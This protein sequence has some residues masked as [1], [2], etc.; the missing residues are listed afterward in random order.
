MNQ[1]F[2]HLDADE[3]IFFARE[4]E[5]IKSKSYDIQFAELKARSLIPVSSEAGPGA[6]SITY[7]QYD[8]VGVA[9]II[10]SYADDLPRADIKAKEF[11]SIVKSLGSSYGYNL[12]EIR[13]AKMAGKSLSER[14]LKAARRAM[15]QKENSAAWFG[16]ADANCQGL[17]DNA[18]INSVTIPNDG[19]GPST[20]FEDKT[21]DKILRDLNSMATAI[22]DVTL[23]VESPDTLLMPLKQYNQIFT[24]QLSTG[25]D[26]TIGKFFLE[27]SPHIKEIVWLNELKDEGG[28]GVDS[29]VAYKKS[30]DKLSLEIPL[31]FEQ[32]PVQERNLEFVV[33]CHQRFGGV[34]IYYP[35]SVAKGQGI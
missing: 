21:A 6:E 31:D 15:A 24:T 13:A 10:A 3:S 7:E 8:Q 5:H 9:K 29:M 16:D 32:L 4:L 23:G 11:T 19:T 26:M 22:H 35:L 34:I 14:K 30:P 2:T 1:K 27:N 33:N 25:S 17:F 12:Q 28:A 20:K 18:N